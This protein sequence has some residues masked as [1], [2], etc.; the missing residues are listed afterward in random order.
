MNGLA[1]QA[2][3]YVADTDEAVH[4]QSSLQAGL[5]DRE[6]GSRKGVK[7]AVARAT[8]CAYQTYKTGSTNHYT[9]TLA[10]ILK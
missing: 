6:V 7:A 3:L 4:H 9:L 8:I 5:L 10:L 2:S 1:N